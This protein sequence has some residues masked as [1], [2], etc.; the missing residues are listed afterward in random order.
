MPCT[1]CNMTD[2]GAVPLTPEGFKTEVEKDGWQ[3]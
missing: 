1:A 2:E 3:H